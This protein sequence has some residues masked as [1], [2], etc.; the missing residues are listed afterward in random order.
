MITIFLFKRQIQI[1]KSTSILFVVIT[2]VLIGLRL[3]QTKE[4]YDLVY[5]SLISLFIATSL[6]LASHFDFNYKKIKK[7]IHFMAAYSFNYR[8]W[9]GV[10]PGASADELHGVRNRHARDL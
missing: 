4:A 1:N 9:G 10:L 8:G 3:A 5:V 6:G 7:Y 2:I